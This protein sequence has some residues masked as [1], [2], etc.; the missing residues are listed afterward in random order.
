[1]LIRGLKLACML[2]AGALLV[3]ACRPGDRTPSPNAPDARRLAQRAQTVRVPVKVLVPCGLVSAFR[4]IAL[5]IEDHLPGIRFRMKIYPVVEMTDHVLAGEVQADV[6]V[7]LGY[8]EIERLEAAHKIVKGSVR[9]IARFE[10]ALIATADNP[11]AVKDL[12]DLLKPEIKHVTM[13]PPFENSVGYYTQDVLKRAKLWDELQPKL[14]YPP[15]SAQVIKYMREGRA[16][17]ALVYDTCLIETYTPTG[18]SKGV[19]GSVEKVAMI[20]PQLYPPMYAPAAILLNSRE[21]DAANRVIEYLLTDAVKP[22]LRKYGYR[23]TTPAEASKRPTA[24]PQA[25]G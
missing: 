18:E 2:A 6:F 10:L 3:T 5:H 22:S 12:P 7:S 9:N 16:D 1:V 24:S 21:P 8:K 15:D 11:H 13:P 20:D 19:T 17:A 25:P 14:V 4:D 23:P